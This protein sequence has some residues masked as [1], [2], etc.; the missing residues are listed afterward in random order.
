M[1]GY[2]TDWVIG[3]IERGEISSFIRSQI[4]REKRVLNFNQEIKV[5]F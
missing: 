4:F 1:I 3:Y 2:K 5:L